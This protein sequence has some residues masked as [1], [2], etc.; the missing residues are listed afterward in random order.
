MISVA[1]MAHRKRARFVDELTARLPARVVWDQKNNRRDTGRRAWLAFDPA[2][3][4]HL[5]LQDD[6]LVCDDLLEGLEKIVETTGDQPVSL[7]YCRT[8][9]AFLP[10]DLIARL[11]TERSYSGIDLGVIYSGVALMLP[12]SMIGDMI[13]YTTSLPHAAYDVP[14]WRWT[15]HRGLL[16]RYTWPSLADH[17][18]MSQSRSIISRRDHPG[19]V[20]YQFAASATD[21]DWTLPV[22]DAAS[23][24]EAVCGVP[25]YTWRHRL[26]GQLYT[27]D[28]ARKRRKVPTGP[29][30]RVDR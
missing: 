28:V 24:V 7:F 16:T 20:A 4:H 14:I 18:E 2:A 21:H 19:R 3:S 22:L 12:T 1:V 30:E 29:W 23:A 13:G 17:R 25:M 15:Q 8:G 5:V 11:V 9:P 10:I 26:T 6:A 27:L